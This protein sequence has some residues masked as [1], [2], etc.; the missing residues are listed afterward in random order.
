M[1]QRDALSNKLWA[2]ER[3]A[4][5]LQ[6]V[7]EGLWR[8][9]HDME[10]RVAEARV[11][12]DRLFGVERVDKKMAEEKIKVEKVEV[13][14]VGTVEVDMGQAEVYR[15]D[16]GEWEEQGY[17]QTE[18]EGGGWEESCEGQRWIPEADGADQAV[19][20]YWEGRARSLSQDTDFG[21][22][23]VLGDGEERVDQ[24]M[25]EAAELEDEE[26]GRKP[27]EKNWKVE[28]RAKK[29]RTEELQQ[30]RDLGR[31]RQA[32]FDKKK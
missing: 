18:D 3:K 15:L 11:E 7:K 19:E 6:E 24:N 20:A 16:H 10:Q 21:S 9:C 31:V 26:D 27:K 17:G 22:S 4:A 28:A 8:E 2:V 1:G 29:Q 32:A 13:E 5:K 25:E 12:V 14:G 30:V 23:D